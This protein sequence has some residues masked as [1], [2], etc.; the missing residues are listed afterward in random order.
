MRWNKMLEDKIKNVNLRLGLGIATMV[1]AA[2]SGPKV[3]IP[4]A[5]VGKEICYAKVT[6]CSKLDCKSQGYDDCSEDGTENQSG[7]LYAVC[8]CYDHSSG[9]GSGGSSYSGHEGGGGM[10]RERGHIICK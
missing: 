5:D 6:C 4:A 2:C 3:R 9:G 8:H 10:G 7:E 1:I